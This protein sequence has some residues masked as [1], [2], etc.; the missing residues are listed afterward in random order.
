MMSYNTLN[1]LPPFN[2]LVYEAERRLGF[3]MGTA[4]EYR[5]QSLTGRL[6]GTRA[7]SRN[8]VNMGFHGTLGRDN[9]RSRRSTRR[10]LF[11][12]CSMLIVMMIGMW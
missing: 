11:S 12:E 5:S 10:M 1:Y 2:Y 9:Y 7:Y 6:P 4:T 8:A 3:R